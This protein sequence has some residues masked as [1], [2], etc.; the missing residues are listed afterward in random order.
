MSSH[1]ACFREEMNII[2]DLFNLE[3]VMISQL[4]MRN[5]AHLFNRIQINN[6]KPN[7]HC[8]CAFLQLN[9]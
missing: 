7:I 2:K 8:T 3:L 6:G 4:I 1:K 9:K 5:H